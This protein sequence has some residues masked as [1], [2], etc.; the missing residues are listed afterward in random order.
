MARLA[1]LI[2]HQKF[3]SWERLK[4]H[5]NNDKIFR[6]K[7]NG[8][9]RIQDPNKTFTFAHIFCAHSHSISYFIS[10]KHVYMNFCDSNNEIYGIK[11]KWRYNSTLI[12]CSFLN[13]I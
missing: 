7:A 10:S 13:G 12:F 2:W 8:N 5:V 6:S 4:V 3:S 9:I 1:H 11:T